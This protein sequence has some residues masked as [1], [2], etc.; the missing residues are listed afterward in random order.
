MPKSS[1]AELSDLRAA[2]LERDQACRWPGCGFAIE[3]FTNPLEMAHLTHRGMGGSTEVNT[4]DEVVM[5]C[6]AHHDCLDGRHG[7]TKL[8]GELVRMLRHVNH[9]L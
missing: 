4:L 5:L 1:P 6:K 2:A 9:I 8:R 7:I 3:P